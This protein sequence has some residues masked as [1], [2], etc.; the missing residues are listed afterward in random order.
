MTMEYAT[1]CSVQE[2]LASFLAHDIED[3]EIAVVGANMPIARAA[4][5]LAHLTHAPN[6]ALILSY[7]I[8]NL[9]NIPIIGSFDSE[10][11]FRLA[12]WAECYCRDD[13]LNT[14][15][16]KRMLDQ[17]RFYIGALQVDKYGNSNLIGIGKNHRKLDLRGPGGIGT[18]SMTTFA[19][20]YYIILN[21]HTHLIFVEKCDYIS[22]VGWGPG[23]SDARN[24]MGLPGGGPRYVLTPLC[25]MDFEENTKRMRLKSVH[26][27][28]TV[29]QVIDNTGF[30]LV[31]PEKVPTTDPV[32]KEELWLL[33]NRIDPEGLLRHASR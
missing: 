5:L 13:D 29:E 22:S 7:S 14:I 25:I 3:G 6:L 24:K 2:M 21:S 15:H 26:P 12:R 10:T 23:G 9:L 32:P 17:C 18:T 4:V 33:R 20:C 11:D 28:V 31:I 16:A 30:E 8:T 27:G 1:D 19:K